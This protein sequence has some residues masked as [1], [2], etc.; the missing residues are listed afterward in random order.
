MPIT[1]GELWQPTEHPAVYVVTTNASVNARGELVMG[2]GAARQAV[3]RIPGISKEAAE[4]VD[5]RLGLLNRAE[6][7]YGFVLVRQPRPE[8]G[9]Y[10]FGIFQVKQAWDQ[11][12]KI[13]LISLSMNI[14]RM[15]ALE[16]KH[17]T[18]RMNYPGIGNGGLP[19]GQVSLLL[20]DLPEN[21]HI[22]YK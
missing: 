16:K 8:E 19:K 17:I 11:L 21:L 13:P 7:P 18:I 4:I 12:A 15:Y 1:R 22:F 9:K 6:K 5:Y 14:L 10:G 20:Q 2:R 3:Q